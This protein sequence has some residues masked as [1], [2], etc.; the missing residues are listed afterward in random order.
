MARAGETTEGT[1]GDR[2]VAVDVFSGAGGMSLGFEQAGFDV[3]AAL[4]SDP[5]H[6]AVHEHNFPHNYP[7]CE[8]AATVSV[9]TIES[10]IRKGWALAER[11]G[12]WDGMLDCLFGGPSC[13]GFSDIGKKEPDD[14]RNE[15]IFAF[16][17]LVED[18]QPRTFV[19]ENVPGLLFPT[20]RNK[21]DQ[22][23]I[24]LRDAGYALAS[25]PVCLDASEF[26]VPQRRR[27]VFI[28]GVAE[29]LR[30]PS[31]PAGASTPL[32]SDALDDL[33]NVDDYPEL[34]STDR[35][36]MTPEERKVL[37]RAASPY[38]KSLRAR[39]ALEYPRAWDRSLLTGCHRTVHRGDV[40]DRFRALAPGEEDQKTRTSRLNAGG[41]AQTLRAGT[42]RDH[43]SF[44]AARPIHHAHSRVVT[45][46]EAARL[47]SFPDWFRFHVRKWHALRQIGNAV[48][49]RLAGAVAATLLPALG[50]APFAPKRRLSLGADELLGMSLNE[51]AAHYGY[52]DDLLP[53]DV[54]RKTEK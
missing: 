17:R 40:R 8:D 38:A 28:V 19:M 45:V 4:D 46:R 14:P 21:L 31:Q 11:N 47:H 53:Y 2:P 49:P 5:V 30:I 50:V 18:L 13:Q 52:D 10:G 12:E 42:G 51:A 39:F 6:L 7:I 35:L 41:V 26:G 44:T 25:A 16:A 54:R 29:G 24:R 22:L 9:A 48:P 33:P 37:G 3:L 36:L 34:L 15:L 23:L 1:R 20:V 43:G 27:R 32:V